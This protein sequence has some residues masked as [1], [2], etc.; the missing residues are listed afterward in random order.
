MSVTSEATCEKAADMG[1]TPALACCYKVTFT[2]TCAARPFFMQGAMRTADG[3]ERS[4][5]V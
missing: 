4:D 1:G 2:A 5:W 3:V